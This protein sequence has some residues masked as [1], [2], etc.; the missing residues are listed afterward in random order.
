MKKKI[1]RKKIKQLCKI[2]IMFTPPVPQYMRLMDIFSKTADFAKDLSAH[3]ILFIL[4]LKRVKKVI[5]QT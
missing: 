5:R 4:V 1:K 3:F 2:D